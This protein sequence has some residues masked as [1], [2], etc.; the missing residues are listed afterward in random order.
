MGATGGAWWVD[1]VPSHRG[2]GQIVPM[3]PDPT[4]HPWAGSHVEC[5]R[6]KPYQGTFTKETLLEIFWGGFKA[7]KDAFWESGICSFPR[8]PYVRSKFP[9]LPHGR[10][11]LACCPW[12][13]VHLLSLGP[14]ASDAS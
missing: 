4:G 9:R 6:G 10:P 13:H 5:P 8:A 3:F 11:T 2:H 14:R 1:R 7:L 12:G